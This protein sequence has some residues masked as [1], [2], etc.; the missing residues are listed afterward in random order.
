MK[1]YKYTV[2][3]SRNI[4][5]QEIEATE[6]N[7]I[8]VAQNR[9]RIRKDEIDQVQGRVFTNCICCC[10]YSLSNDKVDFF[11]EQLIKDLEY[12]KANYEKDVKCCE[13]EITAIKEAII[14]GVKIEIN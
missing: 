6:K 11:K 3:Y 14:C 9:E 8:Y 1:I 10:M 7:V 12:S 5:I 13:N 2:N 4:I